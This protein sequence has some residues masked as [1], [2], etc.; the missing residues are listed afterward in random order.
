MATLT[1]YRERLGA[2]PLTVNQLGAIHREFYRLGFHVSADRDERLR[3]TAALVGSGPIG[4]T[5]DLT[6]GE[7]GRAVGAL[8]ACG[9][10]ADLYALAE[11]E[12]EPE[13]EAPAAPV[14]TLGWALLAFAIAWHSAGSAGADPA[15]HGAALQAILR[16]LPPEPAGP[17]PGGLSPCPG[18]PVA[19]W[20]SWRALASVE[21]GSP[22]SAGAWRPS[23][24][25]GRP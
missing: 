1:E 11:P 7:A 24:R 14:V 17:A 23:S 6:M 13:P 5:K 20:P 10:A 12:P 3:L 25:P 18:P 8:S 16:R 21:P 4:S 9:T 2:E 19:V 22:S 15:E